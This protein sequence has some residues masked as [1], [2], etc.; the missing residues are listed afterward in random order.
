MPNRKESEQ[1]IVSKALENAEFRK[2]LLANPK[3]VLSQEL[4]GTIPDN[5]EVEVLEETDSKVYL[6]LPPVVVDEELSEEQLETV[7]GG[8]CWIIT[9]GNRCAGFVTG[10]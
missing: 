3:A 9:S 1:R 4:G 2:Q 5:I 7:A 8:G 10:S 6:V